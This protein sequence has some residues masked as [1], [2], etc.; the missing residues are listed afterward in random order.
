[1]RKSI[2]QSLVTLVMVV[3]LGAASSALAEEIRCTGA[4]GPVTVDNVL[5]PSGATCTLN[6]TRVQGNVLV[7][8]DATLDAR[9]R[10]LTAAFKVKV[11]RPSLFAPGPGSVAVSN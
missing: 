1:M 3:G 7:K 5:V 10:A 2:V 9:G 11:R 8:S 4:L 6:G